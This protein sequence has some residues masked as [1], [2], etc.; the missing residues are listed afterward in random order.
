M[1]DNQPAGRDPRIAEAAKTAAAHFN[2]LKGY[3]NNGRLNVYVCEHDASHHMV[4]V[5]REPGVTPFTTQCPTCAAAG[6]P[7]DGFYPHPAMRSHCY[8]V[9]QDLIPTHEWYRPDSLDG[10]SKG[11]A[12]HVLRGGLHLREIAP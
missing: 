6:V 7:G 2:G 4:T 3:A 10:L 12:D 1:N 11:M 8:R 5:D 9:P